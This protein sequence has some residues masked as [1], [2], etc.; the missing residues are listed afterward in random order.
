MA[1]RSVEKTVYPVLPSV[2]RLIYTQSAL[3]L[4]K[5]VAVFIQR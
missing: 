1:G 5:P 3:R 4:K 2:G